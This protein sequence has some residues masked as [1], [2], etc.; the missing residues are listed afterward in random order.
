MKKE[1]WFDMDGTIAD[2]YS[3]DNWLAKILV[4]DVSPYENAK[5]LVNMNVL[6]RILNKLQK[7]GYKIG[8]VSWL[9]YG[10]NIDGE[11]IENAKRK[12]IKKHLHSVNFNHLDFLPYGT[13]KQN[14][15]NGI[16]FDDEEHNRKMWN[17]VSYD[18]DN[19]I[20]VLKAL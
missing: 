16:L 2:L 10:E 8:I 7:Q 19:I 5:P 9:A 4:N 18:V 6:A 11:K 14:G 15:R 12:W 20:G 13:P 17:D 1:I 3:V